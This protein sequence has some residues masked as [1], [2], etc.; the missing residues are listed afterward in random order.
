MMLARIHT[1]CHSRCLGYLQMGIYTVE[2]PVL[3][4]DPI[5]NL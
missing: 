4:L 3:D 1:Y 2:A 5:G